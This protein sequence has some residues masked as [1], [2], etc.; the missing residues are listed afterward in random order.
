MTNTLYD[1]L[2]APH[3]Q[4]DAVFLTLDDG[5]RVSYQD[6]VSRVAQLAHVL[7]DAGVKPGDR[8]LV[9]APKLLETVALYGAALQ[10]GAIYLPLN[11]AYTKSELTPK[12]QYKKNTQ[13]N[14][15]FEER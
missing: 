12:N 11:T 3:A 14:I 10:S 4:N 7:S 1:A 15:V 9:Q 5:S 13:R 8:V 6:F 2:I